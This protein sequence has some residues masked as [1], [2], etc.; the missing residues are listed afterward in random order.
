MTHFIISYN[1]LTKSR[2]IKQFW[3][4]KNSKAS[5]LPKPW[6]QTVATD[7]LRWVLSWEAGQY[8]TDATAR[9]SVQVQSTHHTTRAFHLQRPTCSVCIEG[10]SLNTTAV[11]VSFGNINIKRQP[12]FFSSYLLGENYTEELYSRCWNVHRLPEDPTLLIVLRVTLR[13]ILGSMLATVC[14]MLWPANS[15]ERLRCEL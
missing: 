4:F 11:F 2:L 10:F 12:R 9:T 14:S 8:I 13:S 15:S 7:R 1:F 6:V 5:S 3:A